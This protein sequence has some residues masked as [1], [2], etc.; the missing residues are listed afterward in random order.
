MMYEEFTARTGIYPSRATYSVIEQAYYGFDGNKDEFCQAYKENRDGLAERIAFD[1]D[2]AARI[3]EANHRD[4]IKKCHETVEL[5]RGKAER[6]QKEN[7]F[8]MGW[9]PCVNENAYS[10]E[11]YDELKKEATNTTYGD[12]EDEPGRYGMMT[13]EKAREMI[14]S[15][16]GFNPDVIKIRHEAKT[17][18]VNNLHELRFTGMVERLP[19]FDAWDWNYVFFTVNGYAYEMQ[20]G[21]LVKL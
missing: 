21:E 15:E 6:L 18:E 11:K 2:S 5:W 12:N 14:A 4:E 9:K 7:D 20:D 8:L 13:D 17:Y 3:Q 1:A 10:Q 16:F 19:M